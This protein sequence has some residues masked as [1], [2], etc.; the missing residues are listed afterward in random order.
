MTS[1]LQTV[2]LSKLRLAGDLQMRAEVDRSHQDQIAELFD[3]DNPVW[4]QH[5]PAGEA[6][7]DGESYWVYDGFHR[8]G[9]AQESGCVNVPVL[10]REGSR[11]D[12]QWYACAA[13]KGMGRKSGDV[14]QAVRLAFL[15]ARQRNPHRH[16]SSREIAL[17]VGCH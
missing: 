3:E 17:H 14:A 4:P 16:V 7:F 15:I 2:P 9:A 5:L 1:K 6:C 13:N 12:A 8:Y 10:V 11:G